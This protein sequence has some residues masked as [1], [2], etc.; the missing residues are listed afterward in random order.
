MTPTPSATHTEEPPVETEAEQKE[1]VAERPRAISEA[2]RPP[3][4]P[5]PF[6]LP[7][8]PSGAVGP[9]PG[10]LARPA[11][12]LFS[13][14]LLDLS[15]T[16]PGRRTSDFFVSIVTHGLVLMAIMLIPLYY[17]ES[18]NLK[19]VS[20]MFVVAP[21]PAP[22]PPPP[23]AA[24]VIKAVRGAPKR[25]LTTAGGKL[26]MPTV[27]PKEVAILHEEPLPP[28]I[29]TGGVVGGVP[30]GIPGGQPGGVIGSIIAGGL[31]GS[32]PPPPPPPSAA[33]RAPVRVGG[34]VKAP[35]KLYAPAPNYPALARQ[36][37]IEGTVVIDAV[38]DVSGNVV[39]AK[40]VSGHPLLLAAALEAVRQ[41][42]FE[43]TYLNEQPVPVALLVTVEFHLQVQ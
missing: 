39:E 34:R 20:Q 26:V 10:A 11:R 15:S 31:K 5:E 19:E 42:K 38:I 32:L 30:G 14:S 35:R 8:A 9:T 12:E 7:A 6:R 36:A 25:V 4:V 2:P 23:P 16:R 43:P 17:T 22:P 40:V 27:I 41:W 33:Q 28:E 29:E 3:R 37:R 1:V 18:I 13:D 21:P 24:Q